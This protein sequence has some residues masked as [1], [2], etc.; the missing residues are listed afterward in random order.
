MSSPADRVE[1]LRAATA[2]AGLDAFLATSD[3]SIAYLTGFRPLQLERFFAVLVRAD[4]GGAVVVPRLDEGQVADAP[5]QPVAYDASSDGLPELAAVLDGAGTLGVEED[6]IIFGRTRALAERGFEL[7]PAAATVMA[8]RAR[9]D[10]VEVERVRAAC[11]LVEA[12]LA[13]MFEGLR[14]GD[15]ERI[16]NARVEAWLRERGATAAHPLILFGPNAAN[17]HGEPGE[18]E[19]APGDVVCADLSACLDGYWGDLTRCATAGPPSEW[20]Q[21]A[22]RTVREAQAAA[23]DACHVGRSARDVDAAQRAV[24][25]SRPDLGACLHGAGHAI[26]LAIHEPP[27]L[28]PRFDTPLEEGMIFTIEPGLYRAD[29]GGIRLED[30]VVVRAGEPEVLSSLPLELVELP[31]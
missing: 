28:V 11:R 29:T 6:H 19:L 3:E 17:P 31:T 16:V 10:D 25:E 30:D 7:V 1:R 21:A 22:W 18:R 2:A 24:V 27:F 15:V 26:G 23:I 5:L 4:G 8:L 13:D 9:K 14:P 20:A 12:A